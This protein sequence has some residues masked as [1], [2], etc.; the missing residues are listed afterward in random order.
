MPSIP[1]PLG[2]I[3]D[4]LPPVEARKKLSISPKDYPM[5]REYIELA[6]A[7]TVGAALYVMLLYGFT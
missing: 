1:N 5:K 7:I 2:A 4:T 6:I 3:R